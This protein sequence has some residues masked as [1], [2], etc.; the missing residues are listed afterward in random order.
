M[1]RSSLVLSK[2]NTGP[3]IA[4]SCGLFSWAK[5]VANSDSDLYAASSA[6]EDVAIPNMGEG[7]IPR[8]LEPAARSN[9]SDETLKDRN[10]DQ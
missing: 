10:E 8:G 3:S 1:S 2:G 5:Y 6:R 9:L 7:M 4:T